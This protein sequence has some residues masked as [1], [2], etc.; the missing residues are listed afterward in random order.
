MRHLAA[1][2]PAHVYFS[3]RNAKAGQALTSELSKE[4]PT[5]GST[6]V[7]MDLSSLANVKSAV[8]K[9]F[10]H[11]RLD[12]LINNAGIMAQPAALSKDGYEVQFATNHLG[13][14]M[15]TKHLLPTLLKTA[16]L[17]NSD[18]R[19]VTLTSLGFSMHPSVGIEFDKLDNSDA[20]SGTFGKWRR[21]GHSKLANIL[22]ASELTRRHPKIT[23][24]SVHPG[25]V[26]TPLVETQPWYNR[27]LI[28]VSQYK[29]GGLMEPH[30]GAWNTVWAAAAAKKGELR[31][32]GMYTP[33]GHDG[34]EDTL[35]DLARDEKLAAKLWDWTEGVLA[36]F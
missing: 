20:M 19:V 23:S 35:D 14:A 16:D 31:N 27:L 7:E 34:W 24:V 17:P 29:E 30:Q 1:H 3:G 18:V 13:H 11:S 6:F 22:Y 25:V 5:V 10:K 4:F 36:K 26:Q 12:I 28:S 9:S 33:V 8:Q 2:N 21:Y 15:L 32:G